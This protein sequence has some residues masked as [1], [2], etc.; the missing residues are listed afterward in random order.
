[1]GSTAL[2]KNENDGRRPL[3]IL[4]IPVSSLTMSETVDR[5]VRWG[6]S[7]GRASHGRMV[8]AT[9]VHGLIEGY[10][11]SSFREILTQAAMVT[12]DGMPLVWLGNLHGHAEMERVDGPTLMLKV[13]EESQRV[14]VRHFFYGGAPG[15]AEELAATLKERFPGIQIAG[16]YSPPFRPLTESEK[17]GVTRRINDSGA[18]IVWVGLGTPK[19]ERWAMEMRSRVEAQVLITVGAAYDFHTGRVKRAPRWLQKTGLEWVYR[20]WQE[21]RRL[22]RRYLS[23]NPLFVALVLMEYLRVWTPTPAGTGHGK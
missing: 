14:R 21:P 20:L 16:C 2:G 12:P 19:Q 10:R 3:R 8:F 22:W 4:G 7:N 11:D 17:V 23:T 5:V 15:V 9:T 1:M 6:A 18:D 13:C